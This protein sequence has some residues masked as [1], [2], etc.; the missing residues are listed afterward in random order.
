GRPLRK[1]DS[2]VA[3][4]QYFQG[5]CRAS[6]RC[7]RQEPGRSCLL[8]KQSRECLTVPRKSP[9]AGHSRESGNPAFSELTWTPAFAGVTI[10]AI[11]IL[12]IDDRRLSIVGAEDRNSKLGS[13]GSQRRLLRVSSF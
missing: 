10:T 8:L 3:A 12:P 11:L 6:S 1:R 2:H 9:R 13:N 7:A 5:R 4:T